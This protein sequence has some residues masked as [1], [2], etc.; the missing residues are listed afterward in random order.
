MDTYQAKLIWYILDIYIK[1]RL[2]MSWKYT[3]SFILLTI[4][5]AQGF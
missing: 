1:A 5:A 4:K 2:I 3:I